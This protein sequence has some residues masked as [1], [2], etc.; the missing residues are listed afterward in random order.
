MKNTLQK[1]STVSCVD[2]RPSSGLCLSNKALQLNATTRN[3]P[4]ASFHISMLCLCDSFCLECPF[5][6][7]HGKLIHLSRVISRISIS[8]YPHRTPRWGWPAS[9]SLGP[10]SFPAIYTVA[11]VTQNGFSSA[12]AGFSSQR[13]LLKSRAS[14][15]PL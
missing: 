15:I 13:E 7:I 2:L 14:F 12:L 10:T 4:N 1:K 5:C 11:C 3:F 6:L 9:P 8:Q